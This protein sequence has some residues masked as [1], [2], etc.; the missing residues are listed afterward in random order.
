MIQIATS[1][2]LS[3]FLVLCISLS[4]P[5][6]SPTQGY[7]RRDDNFYFEYHKATRS[8][9]DFEQWLQKW[10]LGVKNHREFLELLGKE[11]VEQLKPQGNLFAAAVSFNY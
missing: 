11:R 9:E 10:V 8:R 1:Y 3:W 5:N 4:G 2:Q 7:S 6:P